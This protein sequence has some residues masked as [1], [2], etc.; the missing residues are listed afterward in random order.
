MLLLL[1]KPLRG[2]RELRFRPTS[3]MLGQLRRRVK[4]LIQEATLF[5]E[6]SEFLCSGMTSLKY[7]DFDRARENGSGKEHRPPYHD[8]L[9]VIEP[10]LG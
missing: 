10:G 6:N 2:A 4:N 1:L 8:K 5:T 3:P 7:R 9:F